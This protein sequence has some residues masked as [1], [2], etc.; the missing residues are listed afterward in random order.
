MISIGN[1]AMGQSAETLF[2]V[3]ADN[4]RSL[5]MFSLRYEFM[6]G[7]TKIVSIPDFSRE[8]VLKVNDLP[9]NLS[10][11]DIFPEYFTA[12]T[13]E[14]GSFVIPSVEGSHHAAQTFFTKR[15]DVETCYPESSMPIFGICRE[16]E[17]IMALVTGMRFE[18]SLIVGVHQGNYYLYPRFVLNGE[19]AYEDIEITYI[20]LNG[21]EAC[22]QG[23]ARYYRKF[24]LDCGNC[25]PLKKRAAEN[26]VL[27]ELC[28]G[29]EVRIR[30]AWKPVPSTVAEQTPETEPPVH[31]ELTFRQV[32][33]IIDEFHRQ[34]IEHA[35]FCLVGWNIGGHDGRFPDLFPVEPKCGTAEEFQAIFTKARSYGYLITCHTNLS[36]G[37]SIAK[38][39]DLDNTLKRKDG[40][41]ERGGNWGGGKSYVLCPEQAYKVYLKDDM[42]MM[43]ELGC[44]GAH[45]FDVISIWPPQACYDKRHPLTRRENA[46]WRSKILQAARDEIGASASEGG[47]DSCI[48]ALD[49]ALYPAFF[50]K[51]A[52]EKYPLL[53]KA[54]PLWFMVYHGILLYNCFTASVNANIKHDKALRLY[55]YAWGGRPITYINSSFIKGLNPWGEEDLRCESMEQFSRELMTVK[56]DY[57]QY[58]SF[59]T[60]QFETIID[61]QEPVEGVMVITYSNGWGMLTNAT[62]IAREVGGV[63]VDAWSLQIVP[64]CKEE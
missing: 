40:T 51:E 44:C 2:S 52:S 43:K 24:Q 53:D 29:I 5:K 1:S 32:S 57:D 20:T 16:N 9:E 3:T 48:G 42:Q 50:F 6:D 31:A 11:V 49:Y 26:P 34:G 22:W 38:R 64:K 25:R 39:F 35:N 63:M 17:A 30:L 19:R 45:Y 60:L 14:L 33:E 8:L 41:P 46:M 4:N 18:Y 55:N 62:P 10:Y 7:S 13:G 61:Y 12:E 58:R 37:Y 56:L 23:M 54:I 21:A 47:W 36:E 27:A 59:R 28:E 15:V